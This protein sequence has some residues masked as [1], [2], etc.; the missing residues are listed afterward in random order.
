VIGVVGAAGAVGAAVARS[1]ARAGLGVVRLGA[2]RLDRLHPLLDEL[3]ER[4]EAVGL[5]VDEPDELSRFCA[6]CR[7]VVNGVGP[8]AR[9]RVGVAAATWRAGGDYVDPGGGD[10]LPAALAAVDRPPGSVGVLA[11][12]VMPGLTGLVPRWLA[13]QG[14]DGPLHLTA[15][16]STSD[17]MTPASAADF[18]LGL[19]C[20]GE[21]GAS[22]RAGARVSHDLAPLHRVELPFF[23]GA[24][25]AYPHLSTETERIARLL[26][27]AEVR[28]Y[29]LFDPDGQV[30]PALSRLQ[31]RLRRGDPLG[32]LA[33]EL[34]RAVAVEML[35]RE[36]CQQLVFQLSGRTGGEPAHRVAVLRSSSTYELTATVTTMAIAAVL[37]GEIPAG[38]H[39]AAEV[40]DPELVNELP[41]QPGVAGWH[42]LDGLLMAYAQVDQGAL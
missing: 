26:R 30:L 31:E 28:W 1:V 37:R 15:H 2:R 40:L 29:H 5:D 11:A 18:L 19:G 35:G 23:A 42:V 41:G 32:V 7:I 27:L 25:T 17:T 3:G 4:A 22:W 9:S 24:V 20:D 8:L 12:G 36:P 14:L 6:G 21:A 33:A 10:E 34:S 38:V 16:V 13:T 39:A